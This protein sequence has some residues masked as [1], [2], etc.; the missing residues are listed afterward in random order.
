[1]NKNERPKNVRSKYIWLKINKEWI[2]ER[3]MNECILYGKEW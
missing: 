1:M 2:K 3:K